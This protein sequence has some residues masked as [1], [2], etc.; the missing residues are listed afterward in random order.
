MVMFEK[1]SDVFAAIEEEEYV[2]LR[3]Y[4]EFEN[5]GF[6]TCHP[7]IDILCRDR[8]AMV[9]KL[10]LESRR[11][12]EDGIHYKLSV[13]GAKVAVDLRCVG[14]GYLDEAW[15]ENILKSRQKRQNYYVMDADNYFYSLLYHVVIQKDTVAKDYVQRLQT[16]SEEASISYSFENKEDVLNRYMAEEGYIYCYPEFLGTIF[17]KERVDQ[18]LVEKNAFKEWKRKVYALYRSTG[19]RVKAGVVKNG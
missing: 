19:K 16:M 3:N 9:E 13:A 18:S 1:L 15:E 6:L 7:D 2:V 11:K 10:S 8:D 14:D 17:H 5:L 4:E 12:K